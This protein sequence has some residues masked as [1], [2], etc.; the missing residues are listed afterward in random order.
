MVDSSVG[1][2]RCHVVSVEVRQNG[3][4]MKGGDMRVSEGKLDSLIEHYSRW[5]DMSKDIEC[6]TVDA[7]TELR[8]RRA[9]DNPPHRCPICG[10]GHNIGNPCPDREKR[11]TRAKIPIDIYG[12]ASRALLP[13][14]LR[15]TSGMQQPITGNVS[16]LDSPSTTLR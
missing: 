6:D 3:V 5:G 16:D 9:K 11:L 13:I 1:V 4:G 10:G 8:D 14:T 15:I 7:L 12:A 2:Y